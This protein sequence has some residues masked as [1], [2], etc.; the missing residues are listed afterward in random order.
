MVAEQSLSYCLEFS[1][2]TRVRCANRSRFLLYR[3]SRIF[4]ASRRDGAHVRANKDAV[5]I[6]CDALDG[7]TKLALAPKA[8]ATRVSSRCRRVRVARGAVVAASG[9]RDATV[10][11]VRGRISYTASQG[12]CSLMRYIV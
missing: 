9:V 3:P 1:D 10:Y 4:S 7:V 5:R 8:E 2:T 12:R 6:E 11:V